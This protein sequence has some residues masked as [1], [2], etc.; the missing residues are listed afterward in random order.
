VQFGAFRSIPDAQRLA[1]KLAAQGIHTELINSD[2][3]TTDPAAPLGLWLVV[4]STFADV[5]S[6]RAY[7]LQSG[8]SGAFLRTVTHHQ[9]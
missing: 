5:S 1:A 3:Y 8:V 6:A 7:A 2:D 4:S 9:S